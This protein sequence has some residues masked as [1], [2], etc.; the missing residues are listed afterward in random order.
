[1]ARKKYTE[2]CDDCGK[3]F[4]AGPMAFFCPECRKKR[5]AQGRQAKKLILH[6]AGIYREEPIYERDNYTKKND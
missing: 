6:Q 4:L 5:Q 1:M 3:P 2:L